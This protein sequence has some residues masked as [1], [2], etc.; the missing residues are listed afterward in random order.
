M[1]TFPELSVSS[2]TAVEQRH[3]D[4]NRARLLLL[5]T[6][7]G[8]FCTMWDLYVKISHF[9]HGGTGRADGAQTQCAHSINIGEVR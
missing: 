9:K 8:N 7:K 3:S 6:G 2:W 5:N 1:S 4:E